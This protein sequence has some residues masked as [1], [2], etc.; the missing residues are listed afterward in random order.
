MSRE[1]PVSSPMGP[2]D[3]EL[4]RRARGGDREAL[5]RL[6]DRKR[7]YLLCVVRHILGNALPGDGSDVVQDASQAAVEH[8]ASCRADHSKEFLGWLTAIARNR[9]LNRR[10]GNRARPAQPLTPEDEAWLA[11]DGSTPSER[12]HRRE[13]AARVAEALA[14]LP[15]GD[16]AV[17]VLRVFEGLPFAAIAGQLGVHEEAAKKRFQRGLQK[18][19]PLLGDDDE[20]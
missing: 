20:P 18:L 3:S 5:G 17:I 1:L 16:R 10:G 2:A 4:L 12:L 15:E 13:V 7:P 8:F 11:G 19:R 6:I 9:A 14:E